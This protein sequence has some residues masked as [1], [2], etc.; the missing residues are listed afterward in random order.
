MIVK[1]FGCSFIFGT[2]LPDAGL[3]E[4]RARPSF[5]T[6]PA[7]VAQHKSA[8]YRCYA[9]PGSGNLQIL[10]RLMSQIACNEHALYI[11]GWSWIDRF[12]YTTQENDQWQTIMPID[13]GATA[14]TYYKELHSQYRDKLTSLMCIKLAIDT[15]QQRGYP[16]IMTYM[17]DLIFEKPWHTT[18]ALTDMQDYIRPHLTQFD[19]T[20]FLNWSKQKGFEISQTLHPLVPAHRAAADYILNTSGVLQSL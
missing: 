1:S 16:F 10:E 12:D 3:G 9:R 4:P 2:D 19:N 13:T 8:G 14:K 7:L 11:I 17:D 15:L 6:W 20:N 5:L 18:P